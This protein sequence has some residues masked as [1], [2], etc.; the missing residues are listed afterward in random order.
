MLIWRAPLLNGKGHAPL[1]HLQ[2]N[3]SGA[4]DCAN[5]PPAIKMHDV[6]SAA[7]LVQLDRA[8]KAWEPTED[9]IPLHTWLHPWLELLGRQLEDL[10]PA[11]RYKFTSALQKWHP[12]DGS[13]LVLLSP[14]HTVRLGLPCLPPHAASAL[15]PF[16][17]KNLLEAA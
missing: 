5:S 12:R 17:L 10:Y 14:W 6:S 2:D 1:W 7:L 16:C 11:I 8:V 9:P 3:T 4:Q 15:H 13:A